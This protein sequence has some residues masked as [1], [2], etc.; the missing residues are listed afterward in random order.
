MV[1]T[2]KLELISSEKLRISLYEWRQDLPQKENACQMLYKY[3]SI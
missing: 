3:F 1:L 2:G